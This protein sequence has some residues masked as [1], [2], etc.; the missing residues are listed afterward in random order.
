MVKRR[1]KRLL[2]VFWVFMCVEMCLEERGYVQKMS[3]QKARPRKFSFFGLEVL[4][5]FYRPNTLYEVAHLV[6]PPPVKL[7]KCG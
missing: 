3:R 6:G 1:I 7:L 2:F 5:T 4:E